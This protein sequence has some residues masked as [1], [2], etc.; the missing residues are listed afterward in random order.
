MH[1]SF[2]RCLKP[3]LVCVLLAVP[4]GCGGHLENVLIPVADSSPK[5]TKV[6]ML[7]TTTRSRS[8]VQGEMFTGERALTP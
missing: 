1:T 3:I 5:S 8:T 6:D 7:V 4:A 2:A